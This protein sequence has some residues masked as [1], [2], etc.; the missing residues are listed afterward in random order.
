[1]KGMGYLVSEMVFPGHMSAGIALLEVPTE[2][3]VYDKDSITAYYY[4]ET[5]EEIYIGY[6][7]G[8]VPGG[9]NTR[10]TNNSVRI[11]P[12]D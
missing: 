12:V 4:C 8:K 10:F 11:Y 1:M 2:Y 3:P 5:S 7:V 6:D 9:K